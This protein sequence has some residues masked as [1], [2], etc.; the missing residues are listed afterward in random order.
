MTRIRLR[1]GLFDEIDKK[2][3]EKIHQDYKDFWK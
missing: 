3:L 2:E 1:F